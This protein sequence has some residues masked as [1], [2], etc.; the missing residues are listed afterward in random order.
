MI[1]GFLQQSRRH[2]KKMRSRGGFQPAPSLTH[3][4]RQKDTPGKQN[5]NQT[6]ERKTYA[7]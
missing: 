1:E 7:N 3:M 6:L 4:N 2:R 5:R